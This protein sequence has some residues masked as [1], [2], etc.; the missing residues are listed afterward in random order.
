VRICIASQEFPPVSDYHGG[1]GTQYGRLAPELARLGHEV[2]VV[3]HSSGAGETVHR[4]VHVHALS[5]GRGWPWHNVSWARK[6][7]REVRAAGP[8]DVVISPEFSGQASTYSDDQAPGPLV[9]HLLTSLAQL[10]AIRP[11][12]T[13]VERQGPRTRVD[14]MLERRQAERST[15]LLTCGR[16]VLDWARELWS[17]D[18]LPTEIVPLSID[19]GAVRDAAAGGSLPEGFPSGRPVVTFASRLDGHKGAQHLMAAMHSV[20]RTHPDAEL[21]Y[22]GRDARWR[23]GWMSEHLRDLAGERIGRVH[24][25]GFQPDD[26]YFAAVA[27]SDVVAIPS[28]WESYC[29]AAVEAMALGRPV[30]ATNGH[31]FS[32]FMRDAENGLLVDRG[33]VPGLA[34]AVERLLG[35]PD[36]R[37]RLGAAAS[38]TAE[39]HAVEVLAPRYVEAFRRLTG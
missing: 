31:G 18:G 1:I 4:G 5:R 17:L 13:W 29:L 38:E 35:D 26:R 37:A 25:L 32:E 22:V 3:T 2:H 23:R 20:W 16:A 6:V 14:L 28:L 10:L 15:A 30:V 9:T 33:D 24:V 19:V 7:E 21:V 34:G 27:A 8:F 12:L 11:G 36:L 39:R